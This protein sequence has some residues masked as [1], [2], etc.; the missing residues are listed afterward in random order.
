MKHVIKVS[1]VP[2]FTTIFNYIRHKTDI[3]KRFNRLPKPDQHVYELDL[4]MDVAALKRQA[5]C[6]VGKYGTYGWLSKQGRSKSSYRSLSLVHNPHIEDPEVN[7]YNSTLGSSLIGSK[8][9]FYTTWFSVLFQLKGRTKNSYYDSFAYNEPNNIMKEEFA[10]L[11]STFQRTQI[12]SRMSVILANAHDSMHPEYLLHKDEPVY[13]NVRINIPLTD[14]SDHF[15]KIA[16]DEV[17]FKAGKAYTWDTHVP[18]RVYGMSAQ[19]RVNLVLGF[20]PWFDYVA[21]D[22]VWV[23]NQYYGEVHPLDMVRSGLVSTVVG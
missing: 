2:R 7:E 10:D 9:F 8:R 23:S 18:H 6:A 22:N 5:D 3:V 19:P 11:L 20:S 17:C 13:H 1:D 14:T 15:L 12:R 21:E 16:N 4:N